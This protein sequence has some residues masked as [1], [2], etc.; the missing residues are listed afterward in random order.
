MLSPCAFSPVRHV[1]GACD[2]TENDVL[3]T[4]ARCGDVPGAIIFTSRIPER[5]FPGKFDLVFQSHQI[6]HCFV[7]AGMHFTYK[8]ALAAI[9][10]VPSASFIFFFFALGLPRKLTR[11]CS[12]A[13]CFRAGGAWCCPTAA[14]TLSSASPAFSR[15]LCVQP[16]RLF[17]VSGGRHPFIF[18]LH[19]VVC[20]CRSSDI[21]IIPGRTKTSAARMRV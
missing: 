13:V 12:C 15:V 5:F 18:P 7:I 20:R 1:V 19:V 17:A 21:T 8:A 9:K 10:C 4:V 14:T 11:V 6:F 3:L 16:Q 2:G